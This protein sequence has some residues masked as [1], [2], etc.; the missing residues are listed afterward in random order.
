METIRW[1]K[2]VFATVKKIN[3]PSEKSFLRAGFKFV[4]DPPRRYPGL[5]DFDTE[6]KN[7][8]EINVEEI[9]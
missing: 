3:I 7:Y 2:M 4:A 9:E 8:F 6:T 1:P 5:A